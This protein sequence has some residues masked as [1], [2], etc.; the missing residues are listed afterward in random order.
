MRDCHHG[1]NDCGYSYPAMV[2]KFTDKISQTRVYE[3]VERV[4]VDTTG[5]GVDWWI[6]RTCYNEHFRSPVILEDDFNL[7]DLY[8]S[9]QVG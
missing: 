2:H 6:C 4:Y 7:E 5:H 3:G 8:E 9:R 1:A